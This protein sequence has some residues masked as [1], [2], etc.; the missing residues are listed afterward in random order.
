MKA[1]YGK[2]R[3]RVLKRFLKLVLFS[4]LL[5]PSNTVAQSCGL[6]DTLITGLFIQRC[7]KNDVYDMM[8]N[9]KSL[10]IDCEMSYHLIELDSSRQ[11]QVNSVKPCM[12]LE[13]QYKLLP[14]DHTDYMSYD[15]SDIVY[16]NSTTV[17]KMFETSPFYEDGKFLYKC[18]YI[19][20][21]GEKVKDII[22]GDN[23]Y[24]ILEILSLFPY[25][26]DY[27]KLHLWHPLKKRGKCSY[28]YVEQYYTDSIK[29]WLRSSSKLSIFENLRLN[30]F[31]TFCDNKCEFTGLGSIQVIEPIKT[32]IQT[33]L[34]LSPF[35]CY[36]NNE[37][38]LYKIILLRLNRKRNKVISYN[39]YLFVTDPTLVL[40]GIYNDV[41]RGK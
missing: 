3:K 33:A 31:F 1:K 41:E 11:I 40:F 23:Y 28:I 20:F 21:R 18:L 4:F 10:P 24:S 35:Y 34:S 9:T 39:P 32:D 29:T 25:I 14:P 7:N 38:Y 12:P 13:S 30:N 26:N 22:F 8:Y 37:K 6:S 19:K 2:N 17:Y 16:L 15:I 27:I 5:I 36:K